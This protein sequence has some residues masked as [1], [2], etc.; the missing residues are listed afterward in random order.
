[1]PLIRPLS[2]GQTSLTVY[3]KSLHALLHLE[4]RDAILGRLADAAERL[5]QGASA[6]MAEHLGEVLL[7]IGYQHAVMVWSLVF[8]EV[9]LPFEDLEARP[10]VP[11]WTRE[12]DAADVIQVLGAHK[13]IHQRRGAMIGALISPSRTKRGRASWTV[14]GGSAATRLGISSY[15]LLRNRSLGEWLSQLAMTAEAE[16]AAAPPG[17]G[18]G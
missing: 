13:D 14:L 2:D 7:E 5:Q 8:E 4:E 10:E 15:E 12:L 6:E 9:G 17:R 3:P 16:R 11:D 1:V 18:E